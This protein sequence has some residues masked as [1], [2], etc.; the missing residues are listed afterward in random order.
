MIT[1]KLAKPL[2]FSEMRNE[3]HLDRFA[4]QPRNLTAVLFSAVH[5]LARGRHP[6]TEL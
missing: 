2:E 1:R 5:S 6:L 4:W 3:V